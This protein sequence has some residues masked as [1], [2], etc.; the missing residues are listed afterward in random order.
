VVVVI[1]EDVRIYL[2]IIALAHSTQLFQ[3]KGSIMII[4]DDISPFIA[5]GQYMI[6][7]AF[8]FDPPLPSHEVTLAK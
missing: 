8:V 7:C 2:H 5:A 3:E 6:E 1:H 4:D